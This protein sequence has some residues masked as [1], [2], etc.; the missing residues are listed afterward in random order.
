MLKVRGFEESLQEYARR[1]RLSAE[2]A[3]PAWREQNAQ[4]ARELDAAIASGALAPWGHVTF[5]NDDVIRERIAAMVSAGRKF[6]LDAG[7]RFAH[8]LEA[9]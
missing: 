2:E 4:H 5:R 7:S 1:A 3:A 9:R 8:L 6:S